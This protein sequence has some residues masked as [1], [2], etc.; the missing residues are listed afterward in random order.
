MTHRGLF[1]PSYL[2]IIPATLSP[3]CQRGSHNTVRLSRRWRSQEITLWKSLTRAFITKRLPCAVAQTTCAT[4]K[5]LTITQGIYNKTPTLLLKPHAPGL[6]VT[7]GIYNKTPSPA[8]QTTCATWKSFTITQGIY[9]KTP[10][11]RC[12]STHIRH[13]KIAS[14]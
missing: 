5:S 2:V 7:Q 1:S 13:M 11:L 8:T 10:T 14:K 6:T 3:F 9:N 12:G 4:W